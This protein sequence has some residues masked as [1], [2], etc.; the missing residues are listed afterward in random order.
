MQNEKQKHTQD[1]S[2][3]TSRKFIDLSRTGSP[4]FCAAHAAD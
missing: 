2:A 4:N 3:K 1:F